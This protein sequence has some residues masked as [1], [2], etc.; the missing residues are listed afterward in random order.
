MYS[1][2]VFLLFFVIRV[3]GETTRNFVTVL[4]KTEILYLIC[5]ILITPHL[6][7][8]SYFL[9]T[10]RWVTRKHDFGYQ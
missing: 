7:L 1:L 3:H 2:L 8:V 5:S 4:R 9:R 10:K 6:L